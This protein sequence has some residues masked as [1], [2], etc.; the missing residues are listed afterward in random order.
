MPRD[1]F[2]PGHIV[3]QL[4]AHLRSRSSS[5]RCSPAGGP[6][7]PARR[8]IDGFGV[9]QLQ[10]QRAPGCRL[11][12]RIGTATTQRVRNRLGSA[13]KP[14]WRRFFFHRLGP[15]C[16]RHVA[17]QA[18][19][20][21]L[22]IFHRSG[23][24]S[25]NVIF[26]RSAVRPDHPGID[27]VDDKTLFRRMQGFGGIGRRHF[28][29][30]RRHQGHIGGGGQFEHRMIGIV[31]VFSAMPALMRMAAAGV[32]FCLASAS[33]RSLAFS[34]PAGGAVAHASAVPPGHAGMSQCFAG[35]GS[36]DGG[37]ASSGCFARRR[38]FIHH[39]ALQPALCCCS[40]SA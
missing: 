22:Q 35:H 18:R 1:L 29:A 20:I 34:S 17:Q 30:Q 5:H 7:A 21:A 9:S 27:P 39:R 11:Q 23:A 32:A 12:R 19:D 2:Q 37:Q 10:L 31:P 26:V 15:R 40:C 14:L 25:R 24:S 8:C 33:R 13:M 3:F 4:R 6:A 36:S 16:S 38:G 28:D